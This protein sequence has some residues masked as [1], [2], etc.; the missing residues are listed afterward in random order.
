MRALGSGDREGRATQEC[1]DRVIFCRCERTWN[2]SKN[3]GCVSRYPWTS[4]SKIG[5]SLSRLAV[6]SS[7]LRCS[8]PTLRR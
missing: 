3:P 4:S 2:G 6:T 8:Y 5:V 1:R 7:L